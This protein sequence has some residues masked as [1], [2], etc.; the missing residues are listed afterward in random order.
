MDGDIPRYSKH[1]LVKRYCL[2]GIGLF[3]MSIGIAM[4]KRA[5]IGT[6]PISCIPATMS[7]FTPISMGM[8]TFL[9]NAFLVVIEILILGKQFQKIQI[10][11][12]IMGFVIG[13]LT[14]VSLAIF[15]FI[16]PGS[17]AE[18]WFW[19]ILSCVILGFGVMLE[20][21]ANVLVAP[22]EGV[23]VAFVTQFKIPFPRMKV[24]SDST[25]VASAVVMSILFTGGLNGVREG[26]IFAAVV[27]GFIVGFYRNRFGD[28]IDRLLE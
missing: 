17:H 26:T 9:F 28:R 22:G 18:Q 19:C 25:M 12:V 5:G 21:R 7:F 2:L 1:Q 23:V 3:I 14:D 11:Q 10:L 8:L 6:T 15:S 16:E 13:A 24:I 27:L 4:S 20:V